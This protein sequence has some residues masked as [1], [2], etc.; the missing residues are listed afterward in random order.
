MGAKR[1][2]RSALRPGG[3]L[4]VED[5]D[6][7]GCFSYPRCPAFER[8]VELYRQVVERRKGDADIGPKRHSLLTGAGLQAVHMTMVHPFHVDQ[9]EKFLSHATMVNIMDAVLSE[10]LAT[11][12]DLERVV[13][14]LEAFTN[15]PTTVLG[16]PRIFQAWGRRS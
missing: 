2:L 11:L 7:G 1:A 14:E 5:I 13:A 10:E 6:F 12:A 8:Y 4:V 9:E 15:D 3:I 16:F